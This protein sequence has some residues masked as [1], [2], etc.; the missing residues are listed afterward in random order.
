MKNTGSSNKEFRLLGQ[1]FLCYGCEIP[2]EVFSENSR[3]QLPSS[4]YKKYKS[5]CV[6]VSG[7]RRN[8]LL[9]VF[10]GLPLTENIFLHCSEFSHLFCHKYSDLFLMLSIFFMILCSLQVRYTGFK[11]YVSSIIHHPLWKSMTKLLWKSVFVF[12][13]WWEKEE[14]RPRDKILS[15]QQSSCEQNSG[16]DALWILGC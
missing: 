1:I 13:G 9:C 10:V 7:S 14:L 16:S 3:I 4:F 12:Q 6:H 2:K 15:C 11:L 5:V 8:V